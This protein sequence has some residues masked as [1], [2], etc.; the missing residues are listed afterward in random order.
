MHTFFTNN[1][2]LKNFKENQ[3]FTNKLR[4]QKYGFEKIYSFLENLVKIID[5]ETAVQ[6]L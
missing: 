2:K 5:E 3:N 4:I 6:C 1:S